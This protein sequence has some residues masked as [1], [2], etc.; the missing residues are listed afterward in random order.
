[1]YMKWKSIPRLPCHKEECGNIELSPFVC[2]LFPDVHGCGSV[3]N[4]RSIRTSHVLPLLVIQDALT[5]SRPTSTDVEAFIQWNALIWS[6]SD[7]RLASE[8]SEWEEKGLGGADLRFW[9]PNSRYESLTVFVS[10]SG[11]R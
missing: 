10:E 6:W 5:F 11:P 1:M 4:E 2:P 8:S 9:P 7:R 3:V